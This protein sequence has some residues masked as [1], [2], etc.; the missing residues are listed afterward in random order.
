MAMVPEVAGEILL[1]L[2]EEAGPRVLVVE[3]AV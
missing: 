3:R 2:C 1:G